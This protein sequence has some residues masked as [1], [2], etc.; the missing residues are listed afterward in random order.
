MKQ[1]FVLFFVCLSLAATPA[2]A[3]AQKIAYVDL[4]KALNLSSAGKEAKEKI[5]AKVQE[6]DAE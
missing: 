6:Y 1:F 3:Q 2:M 4:Q 5:K